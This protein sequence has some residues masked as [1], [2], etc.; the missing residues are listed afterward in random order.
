VTQPGRDESTG[1]V[2]AAADTPPG[3]RLPLQAADIQALLPHR[4][5]FLLVDRITELEPGVRAVGLKS[6][7]INEPFFQGHF[8]G[9]PVMPGV[10]IVEALAQTGAVAVLSSP[11]GTGR[12]PLFGGINRARFRGEVLPGDQ[13]TLEVDITRLRATAGRGVGSA[14]VGPRTVAEAEV[15][16]FLAPR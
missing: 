4:Y 10:L 3:F 6:V 16:F 13:L 1:G 7:T 11:M 2:T 5:P 15:L 9:R 8:P 12:L 14:R